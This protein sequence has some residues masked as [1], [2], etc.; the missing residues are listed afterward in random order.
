MEKENMKEDR[1]HHNP[2]RKKG[3]KNYKTYKYY[4]TIYNKET[5]QLQSGKYFCLKHINEELNL[6]LSGEMLHRMHT[7]YRIDPHMKKG[8][9]S[10]LAKYG[11]IKVER[12]REEANI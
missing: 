5:N 7:H 12:I 4:V 10:F 9:N 11:H 6:S 3:S 8:Q 1:R 2:G